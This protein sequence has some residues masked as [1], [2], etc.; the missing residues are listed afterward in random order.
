M[1]RASVVL[2][3]IAVLLNW[4]PIVNN[5]AAIIALVG[6]GLGIPALVRA[7]RGTHNGQ[8][9]A[10]AGLITS[11]FAIVLVIAG[12]AFCSSVLDEVQRSV[13]EAL[14]SAPADAVAP[15]LAEP[16]T[17]EAPA[18]TADDEPG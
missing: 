9:M 14:N 16:A 13:D 8:G 12:Q 11:A 1:A 3:A 17:E 4:V 7:R 5:F 6:L 10:I 2:G 15:D 18:P